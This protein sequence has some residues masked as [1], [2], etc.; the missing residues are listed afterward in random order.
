LPDFLEFSFFK[1]DSK[2]NL[3]A[4]RKLD[5]TKKKVLESFPA[6]LIENKI[7]EGQSRLIP[8]KKYLNLQMNYF[9][10]NKFQVQNFDDTIN[11]NYFEQT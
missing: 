5:L 7:R 6:M 1:K 2:I 11:R 8:S 10:G 9:F 3:H 4:L